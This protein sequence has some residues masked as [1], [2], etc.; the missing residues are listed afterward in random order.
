MSKVAPTKKRVEV[1]DALRG[2]AIL[3]IL[4]ANIMSFSGFKFLPLAEIKQLP[5]FSTDLLIYKLK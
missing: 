1:I 2:F 4:L 3:G 5:S